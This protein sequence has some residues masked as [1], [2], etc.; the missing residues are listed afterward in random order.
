MFDF[1]NMYSH[2]LDCTDSLGLF[3]KTLVSYLWTKVAQNYVVPIYT[4]S[5]SLKTHHYCIL[6]LRST[7]VIYVV[8]IPVSYDVLKYCKGASVPVN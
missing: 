1:N 6:W 5:R 7:F 8:F 3:M 2:G 4:T